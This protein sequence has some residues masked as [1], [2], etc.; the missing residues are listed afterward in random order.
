M[1]KT[2]DRPLDVYDIAG[3][4]GNKPHTAMGNH[5]YWCRWHKRPEHVD[6]AMAECVRI[7]PF[8]SEREAERLAGAEEPYAYKD[9]DGLGMGVEL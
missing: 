8:M 7:G 9:E 5:W 6:W 3:L 1:A 2:A 4:R